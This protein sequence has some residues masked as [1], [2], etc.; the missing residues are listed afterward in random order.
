MTNRAPCTFTSLRHLFVSSVTNVLA[1]SGVLLG[2]KSS[3]TRFIGPVML[4]PSRYR[5]WKS[6][7]TLLVAFSSMFLEV[8]T[9]VLLPRAMQCT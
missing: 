7:V 5:Y 9:L 3:V 6:C 1:S 2:P 4:G 8:T